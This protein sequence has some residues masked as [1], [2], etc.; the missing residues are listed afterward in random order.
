VMGDLVRTEPLN[1]WSS[2]DLVVFDQADSRKSWD[3]SHFLYER[4]T[5][6]PD[7]DLIDPERATRAE[8]QA[9]AGEAVEV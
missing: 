9:I 8:Q 4:F 3:A 2:I 6:G 5:D 7:I 1:I